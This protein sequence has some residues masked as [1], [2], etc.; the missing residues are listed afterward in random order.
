MIGENLKE[1]DFPSR[2]EYL[3]AIAILYINSHTGFLG[4]DDYV[5][6]DEAECDG[7]AL[8]EDLANEFDIQ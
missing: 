1:K 2:K 5:F 4:I 6:Y 7:Y 8:A 3:V